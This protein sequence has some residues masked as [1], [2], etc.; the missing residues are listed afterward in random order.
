MRSLQFKIFSHD[1]CS[2]QVPIFPIRELE[3]SSELFNGENVKTIANKKE[4]NL[5]PI[6]DF[7]LPG[8]LTMC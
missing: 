6:L 8:I 2:L 4:D 1:V 5:F 3:P 7:S